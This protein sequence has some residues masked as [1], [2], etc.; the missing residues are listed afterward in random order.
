MTATRY[1]SHPLAR[2]VPPAWASSWGEDRYGVF[3]G[4]EV[5]G[6]EQRMRWIEGGEFVMGSPKDE[7]GRDDD[8]VQHEVELDGFWLG[9]TPVTQALWEAVMGANPSQF[10]TP[11]RPVQRVSWE[12]CRKFIDTLNELEQGL[13]VRF[14]TEAQWEYA[15]RAG[16]TTAT[17]A[18]DLKILGENNAPL[19]DRIAWYGGNS[20]REF[21]LDNGWD[22]S[23]WREKQYASDKRA[24]SRRVGGRLPNAFGLHDMLGNVYECCADWKAAYPTSRVRN[25]DGPTGGDVRVLRGGSWFSH[26]GDVR[27]AYRYASHPS[28]SDSFTGFRLARGP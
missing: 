22:I 9:E 1:R 14:P 20:G 2:G 11:D 18:G 10:K 5:K 6:V 7:E 27:A 16:T 19:L 23:S 17:Y 26:P 24:G 4:F 25:P 8:E 3:A 28:T 12:D 13:D 15:C 21:D